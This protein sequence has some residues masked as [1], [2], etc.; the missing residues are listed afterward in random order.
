M[1]IPQVNIPKMTGPVISTVLLTS[2]VAYFDCSGR[3]SR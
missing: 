1:N 2:H 3:V